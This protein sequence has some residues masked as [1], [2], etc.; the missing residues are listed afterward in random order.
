MAGFEQDTDAQ[1]AN[2]KHLGEGG[3]NSCHITP[4]PA[5]QLST[6]AP[7]TVHGADASGAEDMHANDDLLGAVTAISFDHM[8]SI[9]HALDQLTTST[10]LFDVPVVDFYTGGPNPGE[11]DSNG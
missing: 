1:A 5:A 2:S 10:N 11:Y 3:E 6:I 4:S 8:C 9:D 7:N